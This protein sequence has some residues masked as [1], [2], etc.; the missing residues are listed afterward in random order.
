MWHYKIKQ[1][2]QKCGGIGN[3]ATM[4]DT[5]VLTTHQEK[6]IKFK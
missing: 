1:M 2:D 4:V 5:A 6:E 3:V